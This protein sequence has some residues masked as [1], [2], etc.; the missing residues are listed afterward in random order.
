M[1]FADVLLKVIRKILG[2][3]KHGMEQRISETKT[4]GETKGGKETEEIG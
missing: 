3:K 1:I 2:G 4:A